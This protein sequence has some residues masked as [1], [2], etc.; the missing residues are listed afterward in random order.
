MNEKPEMIPDVGCARATELYLTHQTG[1]LDVLSSAVI[2]RH[3]LETE[4]EDNCF[5]NDPQG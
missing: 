4:H 3:R 1:D 2:E 5:V